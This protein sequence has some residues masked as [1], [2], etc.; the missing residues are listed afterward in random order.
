MKK[1]FVIIPVLFLVYVFSLFYNNDIIKDDTK[2]G[3]KDND[4]NPSHDI[5][6]KD[7]LVAVSYNGEN[8]SMSLDDYVVGVLACEMPASFNSEALKAGAVAARTFYLFKIQNNSSYVASSNDQCFIDEAQM[9]AKW[10]N[11]Y[12]KYISVIKNA[13]NDTMGQYITYEGSVI[14]AFYFSMS[15]GYTENIENVFSE[16]R[17]YLVSVP[18]TWDKELSSYEK[19]L[20]FSISD[21]LHK[22][23]L[24]GSEVN[25][26]DI[27]RSES[28]RVNTIYINDVLFKGTD[29]RKKLS[30]R[31]TDFDI[32][33]EED[34][35]VI[36][37]RGYGHGVGLSQYGAN[38][39]AKL[40]YSYED[41]LKHYY[42]GVHISSQ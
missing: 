17:P 6:E 21:F 14:Q 8:L 29:F 9:R 41:I 13:V 23:E 34:N 40:G 22:L 12:D 7:Q 4:I 36:T 25:I 20:S 31:S 30:I 11:S 37:T 19:T 3:V 42:K 10:S 38:E 16:E 2:V 26:G 18:S 32:I 5:I 28:N 35:V 1:Y 33:L 24:S 15:N 39:M 27:N